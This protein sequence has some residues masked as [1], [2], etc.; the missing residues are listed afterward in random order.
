M[1]EIAR[2]PLGLSRRGLAEH[3]GL[4]GRQVDDAVADDRVD[5]GCRQRHGLYVAFDVGHVREG[6]AVAQ[7]LGLGAL[8]V[9]H[10]DADHLAARA[11]LERGNERVH[12]RA[13]AEVEH[14]FAGL[15]TGKMEVVTDAGEGLD[16]LPWDASRSAGA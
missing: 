8:L 16:R 7:A 5:R 12:A 10:V 2:R 14:G 15:E 3:R 6:V 4:V 9:G 11:D 13:A 1:S